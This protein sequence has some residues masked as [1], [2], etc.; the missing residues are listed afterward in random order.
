MSKIDEILTELD[1]GGDPDVKWS[2]REG[3][4]VFLHYEDGTQVVVEARPARLV[5][6]SAGS[7]E[8]QQ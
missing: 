6:T 8:A 5:V 4:R 3:N 7:G 2:A 1:S